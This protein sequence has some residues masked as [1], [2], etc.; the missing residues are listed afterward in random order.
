MADPVSLIVE[1]LLTLGQVF[2]LILQA[3]KNALVPTYKN[4][5]GEIVFITGAASGIGRLQTFEYVKYGATLV[6]CDIDQTNLTK[7][8]AELRELKAQFYTYRCDISKRKDV[9]ELA[10]RVKKEIGHP[11]ILV[12]NAGIVTG[13]LLLEA[14]DEMIEK[15]F[16]VNA[17]S[18]FWTIKAFLPN[19]LENN[20]GHI[21]TISSTASFTGVPMLVDYC[22]SK[23]ATF[24]LD[25][26][27]RRELQRLGKT[28]VRTTCV[29]PYFINTGMFSGAKS[30][31][32]FILPFLEPEEV[33]FRIVDAVR[34]N[35]EM[36]I[37]PGLPRLAFLF[38]AILPT[39]CNDVLSNLLGV[40][41]C[42]NSFTGRQKTD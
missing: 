10:E 5:K 28:G 36:V 38:R 17:L 16:Q 11:T 23:S 18:N 32:P 30:K 7:L 19:M 13:K 1:L 9:Y 27:L 14:S 25:E 3:I 2:W 42:M 41:D 35:Q 8:E 26:G 6:L 22:A 15:T 29:C 24:A 37:L 31:L 4:L 21:V 20:H 34:R 12:N 40:T 39:S 33:A